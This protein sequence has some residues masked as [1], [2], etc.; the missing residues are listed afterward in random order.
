[1]QVS[2]NRF[3]PTQKQFKPSTKLQD[4][5]EATTF[6]VAEQNQVEIHDIVKRI[7][8]HTKRILMM[9]GKDQNKRTSVVY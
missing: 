4:I 8:M 1:M 3:A 9:K 2:V 6:H 5:V 7:N